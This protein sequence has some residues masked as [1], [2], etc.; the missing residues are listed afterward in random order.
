MVMCGVCA[1][2]RTGAHHERACPWRLAQ[3]GAA[4]LCA[5]KLRRQL[6]CS[7]CF[8][9]QLLAER[10]LT[11]SEVREAAA[12]GDVRGLQALS[13]DQGLQPG[14]VALTLEELP[15][16]AVVAN[17]SEGAV[18]LQLGETASLVEDLAG[19]PSVQDILT[20]SSHEVDT[21]DVNEEDEAGDLEDG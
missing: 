2:Q 16:Y 13:D 4:Q 12:R 20:A 3:E 11:T 5:L 14:S 17:V 10:E 1:F 8:V 9:Q 21:K 7:R 6:P 19:Q 15:P 18:E